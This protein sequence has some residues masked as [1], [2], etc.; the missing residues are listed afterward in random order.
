MEEDS[1]FVLKTND[2]N[3]NPLPKDK[4]EVTLIDDTSV[5]LDELVTPTHTLSAVTYY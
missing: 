3:I 4:D 1:T 5:P 2:E